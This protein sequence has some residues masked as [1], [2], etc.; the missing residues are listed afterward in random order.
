LHK[1][2]N[3]LQKPSIIFF[4][5]SLLLSSELC[6]QNYQSAIGLR[7]GPVPAISAKFFPGNNGVV[8]HEVLLSNR[9]GGVQLDW[10]MEWH[11]P[12]NAPADISPLN[13]FYG[14]GAVAG[15]SNYKRDYYDFRRNEWYLRRNQQLLF[16]AQAIIGVEHQVPGSPFVVALDIKPVIFLAGYRNNMFRYYEAGVTVR[17]VLG[18]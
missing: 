15:M 7:L 17:Y 16:G 4:L 3:L 8:A 6:A 13:L 12:I 2:Y 14:L 1:L 18:D 5:S 9:W 10:L 11:R